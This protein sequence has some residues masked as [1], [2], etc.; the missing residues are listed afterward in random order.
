VS[1]IRRGAVY[2]LLTL[3]S[4][5]AACAS[6]E[7]LAQ[8]AE[9]VSGENAPAKI[10]ELSTSSDDRKV[11]LLIKADNP[12][13]YTVYKLEDPKRLIVDM[14]QVDM[15]GHE[16][17]IAVNHRLV[18]SVKPIYF[19][20]SNDSRLE[21]ELAED[22]DYTLNEENPNELIVSISAK[23]SATAAP[24][25][26]AA[27][28]AGE[29]MAQI[30]EE[31]V[32]PEPIDSI[33]VAEL[34]TQFARLENVEF[35]QLDRLSRIEVTLS[36]SDPS[37]RLLARENLNR[38]TLDLP[39]TVVAQGDERVINV[40][41]EE[42][43]I[44]N[45]AV[46]QYSG[47]EQPITK[48]VV[49]LEEQSLY[50]V[51]S[52]GNKIILDIGDEAILALATQVSEERTGKIA[53]PEE[54][55]PFGESKYEGSKI[56]LDFQ[57]AD[58]HNIL[59]IIADVS[60]LNVI[61]SG[62]VK[63]E[64]TIKL[65]NV[66]WDQAL[67]VILRNN[68]LDMIREGNIIRISTAAQIQAEKDA[69]KKL[70]STEQEIAPLFTRLFEVNYET[71]ANLKINL[72]SIK[73]ERG[74]VEINERTNI[75]IVKDTKKKMAEMARLIIAL[76]KKEKQVLIEA[77]IVEVTHT[78]ARSLGVQWGGS[79]NA[80]TSSNFPNTIG[81]T[82]A[83]GPSPNVATGG[84]L[85][86][87]PIAAAPAGAL[88]VTLG[89]VNGT[90]LLDIRLMAME[91][92]NNGRIV[93]MPKIT[94]MNNKEAIIESGAEIPYQTTSS[95]GTKTEFRKATLS[96]KVTPHVTPNN[97]VRLNIETHKDEPG[98][99]SP[100]PI[101]TKQAITEVLVN[102]G[103]TTVIGGLFKDTE[104]QDGTRVPGLGG[105]PILGWLFKNKATSRL[106]EELLIFITPK[107]VE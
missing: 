42:S 24:A 25:E 10:L 44:K 13:Q 52:E 27:A 23:G 69:A 66:P 6:G 107:I 12:I 73:S 86:N 82:G 81:V 64:V 101:I 74:T 94:T 1:I 11:E 99:G 39:G 20:E 97:Q 89:H 78:F 32:E 84:S 55:L 106:G 85:V 40:N 105:L 53:K 93:S 2:T 29:D 59:R 96:L 28:G 70:M 17:V 80:V 67:D 60:G 103:D 35:K 92:S 47:G 61:T 104:N 77:R 45:I 8:K 18:S 54:E 65:N 79:Y 51:S 41:L 7:Q 30:A 91:N 62:A 5:M 88:G 49:N 46:F 37:Y 16:S 22:V 72:D 68:G 4:I 56:S 31:T 102:D 75:L 95:E 87:L 36:Q 14:S 34:A 58:I 38:L 26:T 63:G 57:N 19:N 21:V 83:A 71:A 76:D 48:V 15:S 33:T 9:S 50:N 43:K 90:A 100:P 3:M 98:P